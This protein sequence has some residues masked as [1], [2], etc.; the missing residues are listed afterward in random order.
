MFLFSSSHHVH[1]LSNKKEP[2]AY[3]TTLYEKKGYK[4]LSLEDHNY[5]KTIASLL[6]LAIPFDS[7]ALY[8]TFIL[9]LIRSLILKQYLND[10]FNIL[11]NLYNK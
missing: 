8:N 5:E 9:S 4:S 6:L 7:L 1:A 11:S 10:I 3:H 2:S